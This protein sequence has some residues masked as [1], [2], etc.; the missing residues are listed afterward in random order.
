MSLEE[1]S[2]QPLEVL[3]LD[4]AKLVL[5]VALQE[6]VTGFLQRRRYE[7]SHGSRRG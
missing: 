6:E 7:R 5:T 4:G 1:L 2:N 3:A